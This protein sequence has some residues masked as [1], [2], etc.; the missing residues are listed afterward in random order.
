VTNVVVN[1]EAK[2]IHDS[3]V[4]PENWQPDEMA[5]AQVLVEQCSIATT[6]GTATTRE[7]GL[8]REQLEDF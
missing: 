2:E 3:S 4:A 7:E 1:L 8:T 6:T 5:A